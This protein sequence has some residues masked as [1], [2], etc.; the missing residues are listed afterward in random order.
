MNGVTQALP[1]NGLSSSSPADSDATVAIY[2]TAHALATDGSCD[3][4]TICDEMAAHGWYVQPQMSYAG[5][6]PTIHLSV[7]AA[8]LA[9]VD[10]FL[11]A[12][13]KSVVAAVETGPVVVDDGVR[14]FVEALDP[15]ALSD[16]DFDGLLVAAGLV[17]D[18]AEGLAVPER[19]AEVNALLDLASPTMREALLVAFLD[20]LQRP[21]RP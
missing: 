12:L 5:H 11:D 6:A 2:R 7:S 13:G 9:H 14:A 10:E 20:R 1:A 15:A 4:F 8:T 16:A 19:M 3:A 21:T 18:A 17:G